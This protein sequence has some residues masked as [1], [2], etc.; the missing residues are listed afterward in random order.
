MT[1]FDQSDGWVR[2]D[3]FDFPQ[4]ARSNGVAHSPE[5][6]GS[7]DHRGNTNDYLVLKIDNSGCSFRQRR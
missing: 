3:R 1:S 6:S 2:V 4:E 7:S 5:G